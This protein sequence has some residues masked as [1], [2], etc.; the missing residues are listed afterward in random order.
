MADERTRIVAGCMTGTSLD[1]IDVALVVAHVDTVF[2]GST[3]L[4]GCMQQRQT[5]DILGEPWLSKTIGLPPDDEGPVVATLVSRRAERSSTWVSP[6][7][8]ACWAR[9]SV[10]ECR[11]V[12]WR[13][14]AR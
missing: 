13:A 5:Q 11:S 4:V 10:P 6:P 14:G 3:Q 1:G 12:R 8:C 7:T 9:P 2:D